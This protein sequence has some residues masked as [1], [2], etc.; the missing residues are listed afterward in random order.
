M[1]AFVQP[2]F[3][4]GQV[5]YRGQLVR[6]VEDRHSYLSRHLTAGGTFANMLT[7]WEC[8]SICYGRWSLHWWG[9]KGS[10][11]EEEVRELYGDL[12]IPISMGAVN[13]TVA[14]REAVYAAKGKARQLQ[15]ENQGP[16]STDSTASIPFGIR[17]EQQLNYR[18][19]DLR[20]QQ[21]SNPISSPSIPGLNG[22]NVGGLRVRSGPDLMGLVSGIAI[23]ATTQPTSTRPFEQGVTLGS[24]EAGAG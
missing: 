6:G 17:L 5:F 14:A 23:G 21:I 18:G 2:P 13:P 11:F 12:G 7:V 1:E 10:R 3:L 4:R 9:E 22:Q 20:G 19:E 8:S 16:S 15:A 24:G